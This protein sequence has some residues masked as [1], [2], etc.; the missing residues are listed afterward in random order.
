MGS[1]KP[2]TEK[3]WVRSSLWIVGLLITA[4]LIVWGFGITPTDVWD[5]IIDRRDRAPFLLAAT[6]LGAF[7]VN[8][9]SWAFP[10]R[11]FLPWGSRKFRLDQ[12]EVDPKRR[13]E[14]ES[15]AA[16]HESRGHDDGSASSR[17]YT[18]L[19]FTEM[20]PQL[21]LLYDHLK[22]GQISPEYLRKMRNVDLEYIAA[23]GV[24]GRLGTD[25]QAKLA[26][27]MTRATRELQRRL[28][29]RTGVGAVLLAGA[30][31]YFVN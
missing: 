18:A 5:A 25:E 20:N 16:A 10:G 1:S 11:W 6:A 9:F 30:I 31:A 23:G 29:V 17:V 28:A 19:E 15:S 4:E 24:H 7:L 26:G 8:R 27:N 12:L 14:A 2:R 22:A 3:Q 21:T 13:T